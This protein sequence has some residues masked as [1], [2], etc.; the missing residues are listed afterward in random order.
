L[1]DRRQGT[2][3][4]VLFLLSNHVLH[5]EYVDLRKHNFARETVAIFIVRCCYRYI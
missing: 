5:I 1:F 3:S 2:A 4:H